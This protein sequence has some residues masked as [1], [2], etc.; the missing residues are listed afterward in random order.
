MVAPVTLRGRAASPV[1]PGIVIKAVLTGQ[2]PLLTGE[3]VT[4]AS[5]TSLHSTYQDL[6]KHEN[7][8]RTRAKRLRGMT[9]P[10]FLKVFKFAHLLHLVELVREE[11]MEYPPATG[12]LYSVR[13]PNDVP[14]VVISMRRFFKI[15]PLGAEDEKSWTNLCR[16]WIEQWPA[17]AKAEYMPP[18]YVPRE[19][20]PK[21]PKPEK[22][23]KE[24]LPFTPYK[25]SEESSIEEFGRL[26]AHLWKLGDLGIETR[27]VAGEV[28]ILSAKMTGWI[29]EIDEALDDAK[30]IS[31][32]VAVRRYSKWLDLITATKEALL[33]QDIPRAIENLEALVG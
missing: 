14:E 13:K 33:D 17:P 18:V 20:K 8:L 12:N 25:W 9:Y 26:A 23:S 15:T 27:G 2:T 3:I 10:S 24:A 6:I 5:I 16:A 28:A 22:V 4:E 30:A 11:P 1:R 31:Y 21:E 32:T 29:M 7:A 19:P